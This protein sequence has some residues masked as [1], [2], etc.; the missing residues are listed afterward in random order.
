[1]RL[2]GVTATG[3]VGAADAQLALFDDPAPLT[4][5]RLNAALDR[6]A[7]RFGQDSIRRAVGRPEKASPTLQVKR[8]DDG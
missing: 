3:I 1:V 6:I 2:L 5:R 8:G 7:G 4:R